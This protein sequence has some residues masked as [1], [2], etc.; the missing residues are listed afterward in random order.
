[1]TTVQGEKG[2]RSL[3]EVHKEVEEGK[4]KSDLRYVQRVLNQKVLPMLEA[5]GYPVAGG[6]F[7]FPKAAEQLSVAEVVQ[8][9]DIMDIP[10]GIFSCKPRRS[11]HPLEKPPSG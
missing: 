11:G 3:G 4:N 6:K 9:S 10:Y 2:A 1:M 7:I 8:L 5:R